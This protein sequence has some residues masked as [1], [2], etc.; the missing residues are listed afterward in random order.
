[1]QKT[2]EILKIEDGLTIYKLSDKKLLFKYK[3]PIRTECGTVIK[4]IN[5][6]IR[7]LISD[8]KELYLPLNDFIKIRRIISIS[9]GVKMEKIAMWGSTELHLNKK[10]S[11]IKGLIIL[12]K[13]WIR[14]FKIKKMINEN[15]C[16]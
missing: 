13:E 10:F 7:Y 3:M 4:Y 6:K 12:D 14:D 11:I 2:L 16:C 15:V 1:M 8:E 9:L 5:G